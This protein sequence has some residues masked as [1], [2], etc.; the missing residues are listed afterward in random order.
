MS[1]LSMKM[2]NNLMG[3]EKAEA[4]AIQTSTGFDLKVVSFC[5]KRYVDLKYVNFLD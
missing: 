3:K 1:T 5:H 4:G 2:L